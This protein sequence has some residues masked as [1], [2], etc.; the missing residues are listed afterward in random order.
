MKKVNYKTLL[1]FELQLS[2]TTTINKSATTTRRKEE[3][4]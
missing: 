3:M 2:R 1:F 4:T